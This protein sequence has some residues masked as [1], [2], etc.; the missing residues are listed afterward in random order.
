MESGGTL[1]PARIISNSLH[2]QLSLSTQA[3]DHV[4]LTPCAADIALKKT[5]KKTP[6]MLTQQATNRLSVH[7]WLAV[8]RLLAIYQWHAVNQLLDITSGL[9]HANC[10]LCAKTLAAQDSL[11]ASPTSCY[12]P[13]ACCLP[14]ASRTLEK[15]KRLFFLL[16]R[17]QVSLLSALLGS[18]IRRG[19]RRKKKRKEKRKATQMVITHPA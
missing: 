7:Q 4:L 18:S 12:L 2:M 15:S 8:C 9:L 13:I 6:C 1:S 16:S 14:V 19:K 17:Q 5:A 11:A 10:S 3:A